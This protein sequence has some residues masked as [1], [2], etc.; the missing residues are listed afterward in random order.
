MKR[1]VVS[2]IIV[3]AAI[4][5][6]WS[7]RARTGEAADDRYEFAEIT[8]GDLE[9]VIS[10]TGTLSA[11]GTVDVGT[12][13]S[14]TM[15]RVYADYN[16]DVRRSQVLA[17][18]DT[19]LLAASVRDGR[20]NLL[21]AE[22][23]YRK[24]EL[25]HERAQEL[26]EKD[27]ISESEIEE[28]R[29]NRMSYEASLLSAQASLDRTRANLDYAVIRSPIDGKVIARNVEPGQTVAASFSTPTLFVIA[30]DL[31]E[32]EI[33]AYVD[34][35]DIGQI[36]DGQTVRFTVEA[37]FEQDFHG[38]VREVRLQ[39]QTV[40]NVVNYTVVVDAANDEGLLFPG[41]TA[42]TDFLIEEREN[43]LLIPNA[44][45]RLKPS[46]SMMMEMRDAMRERVEAMPDSVREQMRAGREK[47]G[48]G[49]RASSGGRGHGGGSPGG[50][51]F[52]MEL[53]DNVGRVFYLDENGRLD[54]TQI[55]K[56]ATDG[57]STEIVS[58]DAVEEGMRVITDVAEEEEDASGSRNPLATSMGRGRRRTKK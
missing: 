25:D 37:Y 47:D 57:R 52:G 53:P 17:V 11:V 28:S 55:V 8:R 58:G 5:V 12:Q 31:A 46:M 2:A 50:F 34:E 54:V 23:Q 1:F 42:T 19:T 4:L 30:E 21:R 56:G 10:T 6:V 44:A 40:Q 26:Y 9:N 14:G 22:A 32:M 39:P 13:V 43:V 33:L 51:G 35:G 18:L 16:D 49:G 24:A 38:T 41:M 36:T 45:L 15:A 3:V 20:A 29:A 48:E 7:I 27:L